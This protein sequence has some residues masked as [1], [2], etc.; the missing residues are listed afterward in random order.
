MDNTFVKPQ[1]V[2]DKKKYFVPNNYSPARHMLFLF[3]QF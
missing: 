1:T 2:W 3:C